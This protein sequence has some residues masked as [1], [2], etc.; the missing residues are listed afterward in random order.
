MVPDR[1]QL[2]HDRRRQLLVVALLIMASVSVDLWSILK[3]PLNFTSDQAVF[4]LDTVHLLHGD[5]RLYAAHSTYWGNLYAVLAAPFL[6][7]FGEGNIV[8]L[9]MPYLLSQIAFLIVF[10]KLVWRL[11][12]FFVTCG[13]LILFSLPTYYHLKMAFYPH[14]TLLAL[15]GFCSLLLLFP[16]D[17]PARFPALRGLLMGIMLGLSTWMTASTYLFTCTVALF[18]L[19]ISPQWKEVYEKLWLCVQKRCSRVVSVAQWAVPL[20]F[21]IAGICVALHDTSPLIR[22]ASLGYIIVFGVVI[23]YGVLCVSQRRRQAWEACLGACAGYT[24]GNAPQWVGA[25][26]F[27][28]PRPSFPFKLMM[29]S[30][31]DLYAFS[32][33]IFPAL[34]GIRQTP[35]DW[36]REL[37]VTSV[38]WGMVYALIL[39]CLLFFLWRE[40]SAMLATLRWEPL[41]KK[42]VRSALFVCI[43]VLFV[44]TLLLIRKEGD[45]RGQSLAR[46]LLSARPAISI[47]MTVSLM[48]MYTRSR[49]MGVIAALLIAV[50]ITVANMQHTSSVWS[51]KRSQFA[52]AKVH[53]LEQ[54][55][56]AYDIAGGYADYWTSNALNYITER[57]FTFA[58]YYGAQREPDVLEAAQSMATYALVVDAT[59]ISISEQTRDPQDIIHTMRERRRT[60]PGHEHIYERIVQ[61]D[62]LQRQD[63]GNWDVWILQDGRA[64]AAELL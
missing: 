25:W 18:A 30:R 55:L 43:L 8:A 13:S 1:A 20:L 11:W 15:C 58:A 16:K 7:V 10:A 46:Y 54:Y 14:F 3:G 60:N 39:T 41:T 29:P 22:R 2:W 62:V 35:V 38:L 40:R 34:L 24:L 4:G 21:L 59:I 45:Y 64:D 28:I 33:D 31:A 5:F 49:F 6:A 53:A 23:L 50:P 48:C 32:A 17:A 42:Q 27:D 51:H 57:R 19:L 56:H 52:P 61:S 9:R 26:F 12:G 44:V 47:L 63:I 37:S 36:L